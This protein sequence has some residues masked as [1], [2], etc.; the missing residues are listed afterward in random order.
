MVNH[1]RARIPKQTSLTV[2]LVC[3]CAIANH[4]VCFLGAKLKETVVALIFH[5]VTLKQWFPKYFATQTMVAK[6][7][8]LGRAEMIQT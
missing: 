2:L 6:G 8:K 7:Q 1:R 3:V 4:Q 5:A